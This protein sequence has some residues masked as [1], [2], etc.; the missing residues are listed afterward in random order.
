MQIRIEAHDLPGRSCAP[1][2]DVPG[3]YHNIHVGVQSRT[4]LCWL[5]RM[6]PGDAG[7]LVGR[8]GLTDDNL[9]D[10]KGQPR[11]AR[12]QPPVIG[13]SAGRLGG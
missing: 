4:D 5:T 3:G 12:V 7:V 6:V 9:T 1:S 11:C 13:W 10:G 8:L 2:F